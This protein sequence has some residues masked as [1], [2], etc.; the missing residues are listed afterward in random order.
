M[1][2]TF[3]KRQNVGAIDAYVF[4]DDIKEVSMVKEAAC[5]VLPEYSKIGSVNNVV[6]DLFEKGLQVSRCM[7]TQLLKA[8]QAFPPL[9][10]SVFTR[11]LVNGPPE[12]AH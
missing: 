8:L 10:V 2:Q 3:I 5:S 12:R 11:F 4:R 9:E 6:A 7:R 1:D